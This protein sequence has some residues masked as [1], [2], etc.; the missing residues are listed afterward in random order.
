MNILLITIGTLITV[1]AIID[2][3]MSCNLRSLG[4]KGL[5]ISILIES[6]G[7]IAIIFLGILYAIMSYNGEKQYFMI[8]KIEVIFSALLETLVNIRL[9]KYQ[10]EGECRKS[11]FSEDTLFY[12]YAICSHMGRL[13]NYSGSIGGTTKKGE[14]KNFILKGKDKLIID[15]ALKLG[16]KSKSSESR[17]FVR[18]YANTDKIL[19]VSFE[20][21]KDNVWETIYEYE[22]DENKEIE[23][24]ILER[25]QNRK[26]TP[27]KKSR[28]KRRKIAEKKEA[29]RNNI[30]SNKKK[31]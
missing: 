5:S 12:A 6:M 8:V 30:K 27:K 7:F 23:Q 3:I 1:L 24:K 21:F 28:I 4:E 9:T 11:G 19:K 29:Q 26:P 2:F 18:Y 15:E 16:F 10:R 25:E 22:T 17:I 13:E 20:K 14:N 31:R